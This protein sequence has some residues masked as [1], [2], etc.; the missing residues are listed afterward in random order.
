MST[1]IKLVTYKHVTTTT[2]KGK[3]VDDSRLYLNNITKIF[4]YTNL[5][6]M[7]CSLRFSNKT[8]WI[9]MLLKQDSS[10]FIVCNIY[11]CNSHSAN[12]LLFSQ[13]TSEAK[14]VLKYPDSIVILGSDFNEC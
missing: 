1:Y 9:V 5:R 10:A 11:D 4:V 12:N 14:K 13:I 2:K 7:Y 6:G 3:T 8:R